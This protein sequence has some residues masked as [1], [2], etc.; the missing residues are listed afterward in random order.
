M[1][2]FFFGLLVI[3]LIIV[4]Y[5]QVQRGVVRTLGTMSFSEEE[6]LET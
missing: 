4:G 1:E 5:A 6:E 2:Y 3:M